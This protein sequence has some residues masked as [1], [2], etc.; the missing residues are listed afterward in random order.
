MLLESKAKES[1][2]AKK[3]CYLPDEAKK[4]HLSY[5]RVIL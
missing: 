2:A 4:L 5:Q 1:L 3:V